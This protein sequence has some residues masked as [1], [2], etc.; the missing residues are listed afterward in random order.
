MGTY[1]RSRGGQGLGE[2]YERRC[3]GVKLS[4]D[5]H[6]QLLLRP[7]PSLRQC[8]RQ[9]GRG[10]RAAR[11]GSRGGLPAPRARRR[12]R[13]HPGA[14]L[15]AS[16]LLPGGRRRR[17]P[18]IVSGRL[19]GGRGRR[20]RGGD[21]DRAREPLRARVDVEAVALQEPGEGE[22]EG[23]CDL[24][25]EAAGGAD[26]HQHRDAR[27]DRL[28]DD[29]V[30]GAAADC[31]DRVAQRQPALEQRAAHHLV[32]RAV[33]ADV[34]AQQLEA[35]GPVEEAGGVEAARA[36]E[37]RLALAQLLRQGREDRR[38][39]HRAVRKGGE[40]EGQAFDGGRAADAA[41][42][43][44]QEASLG[45]PAGA[46][47]KLDVNLVRLHE[48]RFDPDLG[49]LLFR[50]GAD[51]EAS[52]LRQVGDDTLGPEQAEGQLEIVAWR[53]HDDA[54]RLAVK[55]Q[56]ERLLGGDLVVG[57]APAAFAPAPDRHRRR[58]R[59][60]HGRH[61]NLGG[62]PKIGV[63]LP[64]AF[65]SAGE[66]LADAQAL[67]AAGA[68]LITFGAGDLDRSLLL[69]AL[70]GATSRVG[71]HVAGSPSETLRQLARSRLVEDL[72][73]WQEVPFP[74]DRGAWRA[75]LAEEEEKGTAGLLL[76]MDPRLLDLLRNPDLEDDRSADLQLAQG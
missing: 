18:A 65:A 50:L 10:H 13:P 9:P 19:P 72:E 57:L 1:L 58:L 20:L 47:L 45:T 48:V 24:D 26:G 70:A 29:L 68:D 27:R 2:T 53:S 12:R 67:E 55:Q 34:L 28:L 42:R 36:V 49:G 39:D 33:P 73:G 23:P 54:Q 14:P 25:R 63:R 6:E 11:P 74:A 8:R 35:A 31:Q 44:A 7:R 43:A 30:T 5:S 66:F 21:P 75:T 51:S 76:E 59:P 56:L 17:A 4:L 15:R 40:V 46:R 32:D 64:A 61:R 41:G 52:D 37:N 60:R 71:L 3:A 62:M 38:L 69:A 22:V 16:R